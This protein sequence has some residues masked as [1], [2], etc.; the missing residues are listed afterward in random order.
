MVV[1][2]W[3][4]PG[5]GSGLAKEGVELPKHLLL[6]LIEWVVVTLGTLNPHPHEDL[7]GVFR[8]LQAILLDLVTVIVFGLYIAAAGP[9]FLQS[10]AGGLRPDAQRVFVTVADIAADPH[11]AARGIGKFMPPGELCRAG[12]FSPDFSLNGI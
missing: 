3:V 7:S 10:I 4:G 11:Y 8:D 9:H 6:P 2:L 12:L 5:E 1:R